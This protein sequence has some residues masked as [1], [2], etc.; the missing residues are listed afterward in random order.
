MSVR[1]T[2]FT[3]PWKMPLPDL[4]RHVHALGF[5]GIE[6]PVRPGYPVTPDNVTEELPRAVRILADHNLTIGSIAGP[7]DEKTM[8]ACAAT[9]VPIIRIC[10]GHRADE[11]YT[12][13]EARLQR[14]Y[15]VLAPRLAAHGVTLGIQNHSGDRDVPN[16]ATLRSLV[17]RYDPKQ[18]AAV[19]DAG[20]NG[21][22]GEAPETALDI[23]WP[24]LC[25]VNLKSAYWRRTNGPEA[26]QAEWEIYW[27]TGRQGRANFPRVVK[28]LQRRGY[29]GA[30]CLPAEY[31]D[32]EAV[33]RLITDDIAYV[34]SLFAA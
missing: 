1:L 31:T 30:V 24:H 4:A 3:K 2:V 25:M 11:T 22:E 28:E 34:R 8:A 33:D 19:W 17:A 29:T 16:A 6:M 18:I 5:D 14:E 20:H 26:E 27:T 32:E 7:T 10:V 21:L 15:D 13:G 23:V 9:G 12:Q